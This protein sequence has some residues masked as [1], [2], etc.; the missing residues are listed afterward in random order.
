MVEKNVG[1]VL[2]KNGDKIAG[3]FSERDFLKNSAFKGQ[4]PEDT[5]IQELMTQKVLFVSPLE[6]V[7]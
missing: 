2:V 3:I 1:A 7:E 5:P 6:N 4:L